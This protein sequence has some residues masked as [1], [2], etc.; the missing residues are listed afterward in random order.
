MRS[1]LVWNWEEPPTTDMVP[2]PPGHQPRIIERF[3][4]GTWRYGAIWVQ[5]W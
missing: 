3:V 4:R 2:Y 5:K 1:W